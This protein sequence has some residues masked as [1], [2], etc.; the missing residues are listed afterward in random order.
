[1]D[2][3]GLALTGLAIV[4]IIAMCAVPPEVES[5]PP[6]DELQIAGAYHCGILDALQEKAGRGKACDF[7]RDIAK[8]RG[9]V[10]P[11]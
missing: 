6:M 10:V 2:K 3:V 4:V 9:V 1:M 7:Y 8:R 11:P 5:A